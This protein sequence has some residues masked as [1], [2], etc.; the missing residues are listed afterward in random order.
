[1]SGQ[2]LS[3][4]DARALGGLLRAYEGGLLTP[5]RPLLDESRRGLPPAV[6][7]ML[8]ADLETA[9]TG[10]TVPVDAV[11]TLLPDDL[12]AAVAQYVIR[13]TTGVL[14][15]DEEDPEPLEFRLQVGTSHTPAVSEEATAAEL[16]AVLQAMPEL[17]DATV[18][19]TGP[20]DEWGDR[21]TAWDVRQWFVRLTPKSAAELPELLAA[22]PLVDQATA[23][24]TPTRWW[25]LDW[26]VSVYPL[27]RLP[28]TLFGGTFCWCEWR[29]RDYHIVQPECWEQG[30]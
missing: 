5:G 10:D 23:S 29:G 19:V 1:M 4:T 26:V 24:V 18:S 27:W 3:A 20:G 21:K 13:I 16:Q 14:P 17:A 30:E 8:L 28:D 9:V 15:D 7:A 11:V 25:P 2:R 6:R 22:V 12:P